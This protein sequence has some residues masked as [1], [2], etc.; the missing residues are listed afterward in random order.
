MAGAIETRP[1][2][3]RVTQNV[4]VDD[5]TLARSTPE[6]LAFLQAAAD[7]IGYNVSLIELGS[8]QPSPE[9]K[10]SA[11]IR[12]INQALRTLRKT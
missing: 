12:G 6:G 5:G 11:I 10:T 4:E 3:H 9:P 1:G 2:M 7:Y 8:S